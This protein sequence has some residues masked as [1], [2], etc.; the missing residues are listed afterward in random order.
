MTRIVSTQRIQR[1]SRDDIRAGA[2]RLPLGLRARAAL[3]VLPRRRVQQRG[4]EHGALGARLA[5]V[6][7]ERFAANPDMPPVG[8][9]D[10]ATIEASMAATAAAFPSITR[11]VDLQSELGK[12]G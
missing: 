11:L 12:K 9:E 6:G 2:G 4:R 7:A 1:D 10:L 5:G 3:P 8:Y